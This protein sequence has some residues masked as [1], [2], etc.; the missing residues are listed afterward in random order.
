[1]VEKMS[2]RESAGAGRLWLR[3]REAQ[4]PSLPAGPVAHRG[5]PLVTEVDVTVQECASKCLLVVTCSP[6]PRSFFG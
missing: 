6:S 5:D 2:P 3:S 4:P 1:M